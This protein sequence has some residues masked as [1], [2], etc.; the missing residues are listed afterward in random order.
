MERIREEFDLDLQA[1]AICP[2]RFKT[3][4]NSYKLRC[5][6]CKRH[7]FVDKAVSEQTHHAL[8]LEPSNNPFVC[9][10]CL[11]EIEFVSFGRR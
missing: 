3:A 11:D 7:F 10:E 4:Q 5:D 1:A 2:T 6:L 8:E 9:D